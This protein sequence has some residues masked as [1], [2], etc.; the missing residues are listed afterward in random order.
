LGPINQQAT[1]QLSRQ[2][3]DTGV[4]RSPLNARISKQKSR[5]GVK[6]VVE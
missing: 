2:G 6:R 1:V 5:V 4:C 3:A